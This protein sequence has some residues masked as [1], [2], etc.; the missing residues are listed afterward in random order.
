MP[1]NTKVIVVG[2]IIA[3]LLIVFGGYW[4]MQ[5]QD[6]TTEPTSTDMSDQ[7]AV[8]EQNGMMEDD[9]KFAMDEGG[10]TMMKQTDTE[11][12][13]ATEDDDV[14]ATGERSHPAFMID[15]WATADPGQNYILTF[16][17]DG[18]YTVELAE[19]L[20]D[21]GDWYVENNTSLVLESALD[22]NLSMSFDYVSTDDSQEFLFLT[23]VV[24]GEEFE[25]TFERSKE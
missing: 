15:S 1:T 10:D 5:N 16:N 2:I 24:A 3:M 11:T 13:T 18:T 19:E 21:R 8:E 23:N 7:A 22:P 4:Y 6:T 14:P 12:T 20:E 25:F 9:A 17:A